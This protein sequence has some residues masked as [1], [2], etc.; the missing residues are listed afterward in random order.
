MELAL[1]LAKIIELSLPSLLKLAQTLAD[2]HV[3]P[4]TLDWDVLC[5]RSIETLRAEV[6]AMEER[7]SKPEHA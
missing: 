5:G 4:A 1:L 2:E 3:D 6:D 7:P